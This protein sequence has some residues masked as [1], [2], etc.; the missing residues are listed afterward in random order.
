MR[1][2]C[3]SIQAVLLLGILLP[4]SLPGPVLGFQSSEMVAEP[5]HVVS[6]ADV[7]GVAPTAGTLKTSIRTPDQRLDPVIRTRWILVSQVAMAGIPAIAARGSL[8]ALG[9]QPGF[10]L[11][12]TID[13]ICPQLNQ[14]LNDSSLEADFRRQLMLTAAKSGMAAALGISEQDL[15]FHGPYTRIA[16]E[17]VDNVLRTGNCDA[18]FKERARQIEQAYQR[19]EPDFTLYAQA[20]ARTFPAVYPSGQAPPAPSKSLPLPVELPRSVP[21]PPA[22]P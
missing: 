13:S 14:I 17:L 21:R 19:G 2:C 3:I 9:L 11:D 16:E 22:H 12:R 18:A 5:I 10:D 6:A 8:G 15:I 4:V 7:S 20:P 1:T